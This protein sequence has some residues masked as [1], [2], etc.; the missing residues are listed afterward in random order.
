MS[1][2]SFEVS[3]KWLTY[4]ES[5]AGISFVTIGLSGL[6]WGNSF[7]QNILPLGIPN[8]LF[9]AGVIPIIY[10]AVGIKVGA[11][12]TGLLDNLLKTIK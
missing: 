8:E 1:Y 11:E 4:L 9:S 7:L 10:I 6:I 5:L 12:L 3:H 2:R